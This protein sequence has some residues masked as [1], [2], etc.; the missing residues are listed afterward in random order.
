MLSTFKISKYL[1]CTVP[2]LNC[3]AIIIYATVKEM[4]GLVVTQKYIKLSINSFFLQGINVKHHECRYRLSVCHAIVIS[5]YFS[6]DA[7]LQ[8]ALNL[9]S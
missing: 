5:F 4:S 8:F 9:L 7:Y 6:I 3:V 2:T 1:L